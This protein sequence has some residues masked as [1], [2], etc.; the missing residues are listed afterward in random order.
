VNSASR[1][2]KGATVRKLKSSIA[3]S[4]KKIVSRSQR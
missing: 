1:P 2:P 3:E 4:G